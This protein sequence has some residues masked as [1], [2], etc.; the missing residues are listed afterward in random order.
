MNIAGIKG[1]IVRVAGRSLLQVNKHSPEILTAVGLA[2]MVATVVLASRATL[3]LDETVDRAKKRIEDVIELHA[4]DEGS[5]SERKD[6]VYAYT[7]GVTE[8]AKLYIPAV[9]L[10]VA[11]I[12]CIIGAH[13]IMR[14]RNAALIAAYKVLETSYS[15]YRKRVIEEFGPDKDRDYRLGIYEEEVTDEKTGKVKKVARIDPNGYS[16]YARFF[17]EYNRHWEKTSEY[18][19]MFLRSQQ[20]YFNNL[21]QARGHVFLNEVYDA[22]GM[23]H[24]KAGAVVGWVLNQEGDNYIDFGIYEFENE[25]ARQFV[26][27]HERSILLDFNVDGIIFDKI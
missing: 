11:S 21:L 14:K 24:S 4:G 16:Q 10:G 22:L 18:N 8:I 26:N 1:A 2:G 3:K 12:A 13:G 25:K 27:G 20:H 23:D 9:T 6:K 15:E 17:D 5:S 19:L 7:T